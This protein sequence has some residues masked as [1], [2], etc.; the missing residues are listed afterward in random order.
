MSKPRISRA[1]MRTGRPDLSR[2]NHLPLPASYVRNIS[3][4]NHM[5][6]E[7]CCV[8]AG[9]KDLLNR[10]SRV[11]YL[12]Y[13][14]WEA[15]GRA[16]PIAEFNAAEAVLDGAVRRAVESNVWR[17]E[18]KDRQPLA[19]VLLIHDEQLELISVRAYLIAAERLDRLLCSK[20][21]ASPLSRHVKAACAG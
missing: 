6:L 9:N 1:A 21:P 10:I 12:S 4:A 16:A 14:I 13:L 18:P 15:E 20:D 8:P 2:L 17:L 7:A 11:L 19:K 3:L 5:A